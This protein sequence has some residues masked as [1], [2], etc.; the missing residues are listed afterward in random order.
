MTGLPRWLIKFIYYDCVICVQAWRRC[1]LESVSLSVG[2]DGCK[3]S[4]LERLPCA[5][6][7]DSAGYSL[8]NTNNL[9]SK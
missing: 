5:V 6:R 3:F 9:G 8:K 4:I 2:V 1:S 7:R